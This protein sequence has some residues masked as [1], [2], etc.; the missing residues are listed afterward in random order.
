MDQLTSLFPDGFWVVDLETGRILD[1]NEVFCQMSGYS[2]EELLTRRMQ[3]LMPLQP[4]DL[5]QRCCRI[6]E[7]ATDKFDDRQVRKDGTA[8]AV[9][10]CAQHLPALGPNIAVGF[11]RDITHQQKAQNRLEAM[12]HERTRQLEASNEALQSFAY[13]ASHDLRE[14]L[15]KIVAFGQRLQDKYTDQLDEK[16]Q[17]YLGVMQTAAKRMTRLIDDLLEYSRVGREEAPLVKID[18]DRVVHEVISDLEIPIQEAGAEIIL[19]PLPQICAHAGRMRQ[20]F[21]NLLSNAIKF[22]RTDVPPK[23]QV[24]GYEEHDTAVITVQDNGI[25]FEPQYAEK[26]FTLFTRL[27]TR[28]E[29]PGTGIGLALCRR[30]LDQ[31]RGK[32]T[33]KGEPN[34]GATFTI[35]L[36]LTGSKFSPPPR[37]FR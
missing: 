17:Q 1:V 11:I 3:D 7:R 6:R 12:V 13:A 29:Y 24:S 2:R 16:G 25:G 23:I 32:I 22:H 26:I 8:Y 30:I 15:N 19:Q 34:V 33:A 37:S 28:F 14:P 20:V 5:A 4:E 9:E 21:Q 18:L 36:P 35:S 31:Y 27:H 10:V